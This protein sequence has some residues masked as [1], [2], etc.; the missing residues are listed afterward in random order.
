M[1]GYGVPAPERPERL[2]W[3]RVIVRMILVVL[4]GLLVGSF[5]G[6]VV[7]A[8]LGAQVLRDSPGLTV[9]MP[10]LAGLVAGL[11]LGLVL[12]PERDQLVAYA[13][14]AVGVGVAAYLLL[15]AL[16]QLRLSATAPAASP[17]AYL[18]G[19]LVVA[20]ALA[21]VALALWLLRIR[22]RD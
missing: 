17:G 15:F 9:L 10:V 8:A 4:P 19:P 21:V 5:A 22:A 18:L 6:G 7:V 1:P 11:G 14:A 12:K 2:P 20:V 13:L 3:P 16:S